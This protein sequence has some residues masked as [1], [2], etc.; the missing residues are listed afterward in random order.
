MTSDIGVQPI[1]V[2]LEQRLISMPWNGPG[3]PRLTL[4][5]RTGLWGERFRG[6]S[7]S[8][9]GVLGRSQEGQQ[10]GC[11]ANR[12]TIYAVL[13]S[14]PCTPLPETPPRI[15]SKSSP[16][17][18]W[19]PG[20]GQTGPWDPRWTHLPQLRGP[21]LVLALRGYLA[22][23]DSPQLPPFWA[24]PTQ[25]GASLQLLGHPPPLQAKAPQKKR[26]CCLHPCARRPRP[27]ARSAWATNP[28][29]LGA[30]GPSGVTA[31]PQAGMASGSS[32]DT[33]NTAW[34]RVVQVGAPL[35][36]RAQSAAGNIRG[37]TGEYVGVWHCVAAFVCMHNCGCV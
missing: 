35:D 25:G 1:S 22:H 7:C 5:S 14:W 10:G 30:Q 6:G 33:S 26:G 28:V 3:R 34:V 18:L 4:I 29:S 31:R 8:H 11:R 21:T 17:P 23:P 19:T 24:R 2:P 32:E 37:A 13:N 20:I 12:G 9:Y 36:R 16:E 27:L 15:P